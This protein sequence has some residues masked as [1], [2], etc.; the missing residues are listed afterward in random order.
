MPCYVI[1]INLQ[2]QLVLLSLNFAA[3]CERSLANYFKDLSHSSRYLN[4]VML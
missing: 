2:I 4:V 3:E 1:V